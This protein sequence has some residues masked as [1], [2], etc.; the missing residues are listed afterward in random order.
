MVDRKTNDD[1]LDKTERKESGDT[2][3]VDPRQPWERK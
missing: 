3:Q 1:K 2:K